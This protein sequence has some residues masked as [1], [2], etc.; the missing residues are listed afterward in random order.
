MAG[1]LILLKLDDSKGRGH[2]HGLSEDL[3][4]GAKSLTIGRQ[5]FDCWSIYKHAD[6]SSEWLP[7]KIVG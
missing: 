5:D 3:D 2:V 7:C 4:L 1:N 6:N